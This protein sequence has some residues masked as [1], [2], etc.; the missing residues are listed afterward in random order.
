MSIDDIQ[1]KL[2]EAV[3][4]L[5]GSGSVQ[6]R[7]G[8]AGEYLAQIEESAAVAFPAM[9]GSQARLAEIRRRLTARGSIHETTGT[10]TD[11]AASEVARD[12]LSLFIDATR[13]AGIATGATDSANLPRDIN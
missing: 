2:W 3:N 4:V 5:V 9:I 8:H 1:K 12:I 11:E 13:A 10:L 6:V 7:L